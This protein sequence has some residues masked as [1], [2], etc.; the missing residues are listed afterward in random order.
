[1]ERVSGDWYKIV[2]P[3][4]G[5]VINVQWGHRNNA[6]QLWLYHYDGTASC[7]WR[8]R[9]LGNGVYNI[10]SQLETNPFLEVQNGNPFN[11]AILQIW[12]QH[13]GDAAKW[14]LKKA[15][16]VDHSREGIQ[17]R[18]MQ[19]VFHT[20]NGTKISKGGDFDGYI[21]LKK[22]YGYIHEG[23]DLVLYH[24]A[25]VYAVTSGTVVRA[26]D[27]YG[28]T[29]AIYNENINKTIVYLH[30]DRVA[31]GISVG[32]RVDQ[33]TL[34]G[35]QGNKDAPQGSHVHIEIRPGKQ[36]SA[37]KS[38]NTTQENPNPYPYWDQLLQ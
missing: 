36:T 1:M 28:N 9:D 30:F 13:S 26:G 8:F 31:S 10:E 29:V 7:H 12:Q 15:D 16:T 11:N 35:Y 14:K 27:G 2:H 22:N 4:S 33:N 5:H 37:A 38:S 17:K 20:T 34:I 18:L 21:E 3:T 6:T 19:A 23:I 32:S 24:G 25:P